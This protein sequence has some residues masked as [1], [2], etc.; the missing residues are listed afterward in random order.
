M[1]MNTVVNKDIFYRLNDKNVIWIFG[2]DETG[3][4]N[5]INKHVQ[6]NT[7]LANRRNVFIMDK[8]A[9]EAC[10]NVKNLF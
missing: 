10:K 3:G 6:R 8:E 2:A 1:L 5:Y 7:M 4:Y 9:M